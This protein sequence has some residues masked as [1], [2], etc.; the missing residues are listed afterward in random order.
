MSDPRYAMQSRTI[1]AED[2]EDD[3]FCEYTPIPNLGKIY[4]RLLLA[5]LEIHNHIKKNSDILVTGGTFFFKFD[6]KDRPFLV[7]AT[8]IKTE[9][10]IPILNAKVNFALFPCANRIIEREPRATSPKG[11]MRLAG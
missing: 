4:E 2:Q 9:R 1:T 8:K 10:P 7:F 5:M 3:N 11:N 6:T